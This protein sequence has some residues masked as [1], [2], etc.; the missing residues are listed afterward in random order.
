M[1]PHGPGGHHH[2]GGFRR[3]E[4]GTEDLEAFLEKANIRAQNFRVLLT[5]DEVKAIQQAAIWYFTNY[6]EED[7]KY[8][9]RNK[10]NGIWFFYT[11]NGRNYT[12][13]SSYGL[14]ETN[15]GTMRQ[16]QAQMLY[17]Y[18]IDTAKANA[19]FNRHS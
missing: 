9:M 15:E 17:N 12:S 4:D 16:I 1:V 8:D 13:L 3:A 6:G 10:E 7:G 14:H 2:R 11:E 19:G 18:L 5:V